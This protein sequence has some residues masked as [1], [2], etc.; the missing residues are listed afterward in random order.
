MCWEEQSCCHGNLFSFGVFLICIRAL[1]SVCF[2]V[3]LLSPMASHKKWW[4]SV[5]Q[6]WSIYLWHYLNIPR[7]PICLD[8]CT[9]MRNYFWIQIWKWWY[10]YADV[11]SRLERLH[12]GA[13]PWSASSSRQGR[14]Q[15]RWNSINQRGNLASEVTPLYNSPWTKYHL[16]ALSRTWHRRGRTIQTSFSAASGRGSSSTAHRLSR[17]QSQK[18]PIC[19]WEWC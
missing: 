8:A 2:T 12:Q 16:E 9:V 15:P 5:L 17:W 18:G 10:S 19:I 13:L 6:R 11:D 1:S 3:S 4:K 7:G 14:T